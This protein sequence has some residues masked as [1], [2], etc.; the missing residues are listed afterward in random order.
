[1]WSDLELNGVVALSRHLQSPY[2]VFLKGIA[3]LAL[4]P[5]VRLYSQLM[6]KN[7]CLDTCT[8]CYKWRIVLDRIETHNFKEVGPTNE[9]PTFS[10][11]QKAGS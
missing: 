11:L 7:T 6:A 9:Q 1:M 4:A 3:T 8:T 5:I 10:H 2:R